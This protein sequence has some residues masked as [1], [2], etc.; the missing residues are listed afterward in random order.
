VAVSEKESTIMFTVGEFSQVAQVSK[1][2]LRYYDEIGLLKPLHTDRFTGYRYYSAEQLPQLNRIIALK[3][4]G[5]SLEQIQDILDNKVSADEIH[6]MLLLKKAEIEQQLQSEQQRIRNIES[7]LQSIRNAEAHQSLDVVVKHI[8]PQPVLSV[9]TMIEDF[10]VGLGIA[11]QIMKELPQKSPYGLF[12]VIWYSGGFYEQDS[13][14]EICRIVEAKSH[15]PVP[16]TNELR[17]CFR[18]LP[19]VETMAT[20]VVKGAATN[21]HTGYSAIGTWA[22]VNNYRFVDAPREVLLNLPQAADGSDGITEIQFPVEP[23]R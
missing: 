11:G 20:F 1:R 15:P 17:L 14:V 4:L 13:D 3:D 19:A 2:L 21:V 5:L 10:G 22:E 23:I 8:P 6:G 16:L 18:E 9:R 7:R 12:V